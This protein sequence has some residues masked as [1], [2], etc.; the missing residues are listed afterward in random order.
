MSK[1]MRAGCVDAEVIQ[2]PGP[3]GVKLYL[4]AFRK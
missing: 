1:E 4:G 3:G 2:V